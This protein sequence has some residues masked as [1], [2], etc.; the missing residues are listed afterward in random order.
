MRQ[1]DCQERAVKIR[2]K[3]FLGIGLTHHHGVGFDQ[4]CLSGVGFLLYDKEG[5]LGG[6]KTNLKLTVF[7][8]YL[9]ITVFGSP[10]L[11]EEV[12]SVIVGIRVGGVR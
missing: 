4:L 8:S 10:P 1:E 11:P 7:P 6:L 3:V 5:D 9:G 12:P 2:V